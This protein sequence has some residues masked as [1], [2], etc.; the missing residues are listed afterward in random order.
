MRIIKSS[1]DPYIQ[2]MKNL[3]HI[4]TICNHV[5]YWE[6][7]CLILHMNWLKSNTLLARQTFQKFPTAS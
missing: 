4:A 3:V 5:I 7:V 6:Q 1:D 2:V